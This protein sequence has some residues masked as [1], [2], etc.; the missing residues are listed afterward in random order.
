MNISTL[1]Q[2]C[3]GDMG[4]DQN[5]WVMSYHIVG[6]SEHPNLPAVLVFTRGFHWFWIIW[7]DWGDCSLTIPKGRWVADHFSLVNDFR[8]QNLDFADTYIPINLEIVAFPSRRRWPY[9][10]SLLCFGSWLRKGASVLRRKSAGPTLKSAMAF[11]DFWCGNSWGFCWRNN[12]NNSWENPHEIN[13]LPGWYCHAHFA[14][15]LLTF[16][17]STVAK[18][19][20]RRCLRV[21]LK[22]PHP[23]VL[24]RFSWLT[25]S[26]YVQLLHNLV[27]PKA[28]ARL[29]VTTPP[30]VA[31]TS[32]I[33]P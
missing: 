5:R 21:R 4:M 28:W 17:S 15:R 32:Q 16:G 14:I 20:C 6:G 24:G 30:P 3:P 26:A 10:R 25:A 18:H 9:R 13:I 8:I 29:A 11:E 7:S 22:S 23:A 12:N 2:I 1:D 27:I 31:L 33:G 19:R